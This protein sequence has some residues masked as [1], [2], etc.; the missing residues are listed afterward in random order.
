MIYMI[1]SL[2]PKSHGPHPFQVLQEGR[3]GWSLGILLPGREGGEDLPAIL[4]DARRLQGPGVRLTADTLANGSRD[5]FFEEPADG[6]ET[7]VGARWEGTG[8]V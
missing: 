2:S 1:L 3:E 8:G 4:V 7:A 5:L 6:Q